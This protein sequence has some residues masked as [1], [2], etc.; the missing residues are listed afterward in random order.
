MSTDEIT[1]AQEKQAE[2]EAE[3]EGLLLLLAVLVRRLEDEPGAGVVITEAEID[4]LEGGS[5]EMESE[6]GESL[7]VKVV[8][9]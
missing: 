5:V 1:L 4:E 9:S 7:N 8:D 2:A 6:D 3:S